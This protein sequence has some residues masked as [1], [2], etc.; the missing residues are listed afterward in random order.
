M[1]WPPCARSMPG[2]CR[3]ASARRGTRP[4]W[5][6]R[7]SA[8]ARWRARRR[9]AL[10]AVD[11]E[12]LDD[13]HVLAAAVVALPRIA[14]RVLVR[15]H[16]A[17]ASS[18]A[19]QTKFSLAIS[20][21]PACWRSISCWMASAISGSAARGVRLGRGSGAWPSSWECTIRSYAGIM[22]LLLRV[23]GR[24]DKQVQPGH[25][26]IC[27][28][29]CRHRSIRRPAVLRVK[30]GT[31]VTLGARSTAIGRGSPSEC[32]RPRRREMREQRA[33]ATDSARPRRFAGPGHRR[34]RLAAHP[35]QG[36][37]ASLAHRRSLRTAPRHPGALPGDGPAAARTG[38]HAG[39]DGRARTGILARND[40]Q[41]RLLEGLEQ[42]VEV[43]HGEVPET[44]VVLER[45]V[46][47][48]W[49][50]ATDRRPGSSSISA[51]TARR[52]RLRPRAGA[53]LLRL[54]RRIRDG[55]RR[56]CE[57]SKRSSLGE[58]VGAQGNAAR[59]GVSNITPP[60]RT[61]STSSATSRTTASDSTRS[62]SIRRRLRR[63]RRRCHK[64]IA[65][66]KDINLRALRLLRPGYRSLRR[67]A[68]IT[69]TR[70]PLQEVI[71]EASVDSDV[72][73][74]VIEKRMQGRDHPVLLGVPETYYLKCLIPPEGLAARAPARKDRLCAVRVRT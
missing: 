51:R 50:R 72:P 58:A 73:V 34:D 28:S 63:T 9:T 24:A 10:R 4:C 37:P 43:L 11:G 44:I 55:P 8:A 32:S 17:H 65:G 5:P 42:H 70:P 59:N 69:W 61:S 33:G 6:A 20:S 22:S 13:V 2:S 26:S 30:P 23:F 47:S 35:R 60:K 62:C 7:R 29:R 41:V 16:R 38:P 49:T 67:A 18:T 54:Q 31:S 71:Y 25:P 1:R 3:P 46:T 66:Y 14:F 56:Q 53:R 64:A 19:R 36:R 45:P 48:K 40:P 12:L 52:R 21:R 68:P 39:G 57:R 15:E 74:T 27:P